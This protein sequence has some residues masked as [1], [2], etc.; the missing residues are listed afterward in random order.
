MSQLN[1]IAL[2][3]LIFNHPVYFVASPIRRHEKLRYSPCFLPML[4]QST[5]LVKL[6]LFI[7]YIKFSMKSPLQAF[8]SRNVEYFH[9]GKLCI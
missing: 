6:P 1:R 7:L 4:F 9:V 5:P 2:Y 3:T 8:K